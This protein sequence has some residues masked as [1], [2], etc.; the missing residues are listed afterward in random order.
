LFYVLDLGIIVPLAVIAAVWL[1]QERPWG[2]VLAGYILIKATT[3]GLALV[4]MTWFMGRA[5]FSVDTKL[6]GFWIILTLGSA[7]MSTWFLHHCRSA[8]TGRGIHGGL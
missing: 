5:G 2:F 4:S 1:Y 7:G 6:S 3:M 8:D